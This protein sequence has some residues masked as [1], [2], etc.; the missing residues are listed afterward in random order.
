FIA[1]TFELAIL[2][3]ALAAFFG[4]LLLNGLPRL[5]HPVFNAP[6]FDLASKSRFFLCIRSSDPSFDAEA[7]ER[8]LRESQPVRVM[9][10]ER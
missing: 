10:V 2:G 9:R 6:D 5:R 7:T 4:F 8:L 3:A 1:P